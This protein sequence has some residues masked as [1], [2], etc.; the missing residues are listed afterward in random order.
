[1][2]SLRARNGNFLAGAQRALRETGDLYV[3]LDCKNTPL[4]PELDVD[5]DD[6]EVYSFLEIVD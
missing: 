2:L 5:D 4:L 3:T 6:D 1:L